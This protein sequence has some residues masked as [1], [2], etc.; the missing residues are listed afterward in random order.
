MTA[1]MMVRVSAIDA[2]TT[3]EAQMEGFVRIT[4]AKTLPPRKAASLLAA[5]TRDVFGQRE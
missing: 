1:D 5:L 2:Y 3:E 4:P